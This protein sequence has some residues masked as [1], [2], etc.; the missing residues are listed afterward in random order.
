MS[1][2][3]M[4]FDAPNRDATSAPDHGGNQHGDFIWYE[5][6]TSDAEAAAD[7]YGAVTG[8]KAR[9]AGMPDISYSLF[10]SPE[11]A[12]IGGLLTL[13]EGMKAGGARPGWFAYV[14]VDDVDQ[15]VRA[16][17]EAGGVVQMPPTDI[18]GVGRLAMVTDPQGAPFYVMRGASDE[19]SLAFASDRPRIGH[20]AWNE[21]ST[22]D[23]DAARQFYG[24]IFGWTKDGEMSMGELGA[25]EFWR[26]KSGLFG[27]VM[28]LMP[29]HRVSAWGFYFRVPDI[30]AAVR[31]ITERGGAIIQGPTEIPGGEFSINA[32]DPQGAYFGLVGP[33]Q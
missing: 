8:W 12:D 3:T 30:D 9:D 21:L 7:F 18:P 17:Q 29:G 5:L 22:A 16:V 33:R 13:T 15:T 19:P 25:Y 27:A 23:P 2:S 14:G 4:T 32:A 28:P 1:D 10:S 11:G 6:L 26:N 20:C 24:D 31:S